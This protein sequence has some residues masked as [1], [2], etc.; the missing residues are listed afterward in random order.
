MAGPELALRVLA[1]PRLQTDP[2]AIVAIAHAPQVWTDDSVQRVVATAL[3]SRAPLI[4]QDPRT[5]EPVLFA[6]ATLPGRLSPALAALMLEHPAVAHSP[7]TLAV[8][9]ARAAGTE[10]AVRARLRLAALGTTV[11]SELLTII[12]G[13]TEQ[14]IPAASLSVV[15][16]AAGVSVAR[17]NPVIPQ[18]RISC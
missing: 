9:A 4:A 14:R 11:Q 16:E 3:T 2:S 12:Q 15:A 13:A 6:I 5:E 7:R 17:R 8:L 10:V 18:R 1:S